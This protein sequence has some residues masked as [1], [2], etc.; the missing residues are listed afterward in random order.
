MKYLKHLT[1]IRQVFQFTWCIYD[2]IGISGVL[3]L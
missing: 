1:F 2:C 3:Y